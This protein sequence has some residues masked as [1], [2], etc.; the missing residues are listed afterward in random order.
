[1]RDINT[2]GASLARA[3]RAC[4]GNRITQEAAQAEQARLMMDGLAAGLPPAQ[5]SENCSCYLNIS[6]LNQ[7]LERHGVVKTDRAV[8]AYITVVKAELAKPAP[9]PKK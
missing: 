5:I 1:M 7:D 6:A 3:I 9:A 4:N 8:P 2:V